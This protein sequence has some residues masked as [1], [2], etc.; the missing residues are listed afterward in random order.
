[1][2]LDGPYYAAKPQYCKI[3]GVFLFILLNSLLMGLLAETCCWLY[4]T[5][6]KWNCVCT[7]RIIFLIIQNTKPGWITLKFKIQL[8]SMESKLLPLYIYISCVMAWELKCGNRKFLS[9][10]AVITNFCQN[11]AFIIFNP[12]NKRRWFGTVC[13]PHQ[14][15]L[16]ILFHNATHP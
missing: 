11:I 16:L 3:V 14:H 9:V 7:G 10:F 15:S 8:V 2:H 4:C 13:V 12:E 5:I 6:D 1:V